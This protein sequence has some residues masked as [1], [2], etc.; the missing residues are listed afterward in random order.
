MSFP[1]IDVNASNKAGETALGIAEKYFNEEIAT[2]I[3]EA[4]GSVMARKEEI[5]EIEEIQIEKDPPLPTRAP[6]Q[7]KQAVSFLKQELK[8]QA[9]N[10]RKTQ[11]GV[12]EL[13]KKVGKMVKSGL[14]KANNSNIIVATLIF[15]SAFG[16]IFQVPGQYTSS[17]GDG[18]SVGQAYISNG[19]AFSIFLLSDCF[20]LFVSLA[21][22]VAQTSLIVVDQ[23]AMKWMIFVINKL[24][25]A[26]CISISVA[27]VSLSYVVIR[28]H[29][30][31]LA[32][33]TLMVAV[34]ILI[35]TFGI[36]CSCVITHWMHRKKLKHSVKRT[37]TAIGESY[38]RRAT[39]VSYT[40]LKAK[41]KKQMYAI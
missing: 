38:S 23:K 31:W 28:R 21:V 9:R 35:S 33:A 39:L 19:P 3:R 30:W 8:F 32:W 15:S 1:G 6:N 40:L 14:S 20:A 36:M 13:K 24:M 26:C 34:V 29:D 18:Y 7:L 12:D 10:S 4:G 11:L 16:A 5:Q 17:D 41:C 22:V 37:A 27:F 25:W 2:V